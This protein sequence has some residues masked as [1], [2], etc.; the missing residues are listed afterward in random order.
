MSITT[1]DV[2]LLLGPEFVGTAEASVDPFREA[3]ELVVAEDLAGAGHSTARLDLIAKYMSA[4]FATVS[5]ER[6]GLTR[7]KVGESADTY[8]TGLDS[9]QGY[10]LTRFGQ[11]AVSLDSSGILALNAAPRQKAEFRVV[12]PASSV[13]YGNDDSPN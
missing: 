3:A 2:I 13:E 10:M 11:Q 7:Q 1:S 12:T 9:D 6:G 5:F 4:H 8:K